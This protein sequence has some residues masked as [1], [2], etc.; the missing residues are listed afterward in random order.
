M[1]MLLHRRAKTP[2]RKKFTAPSKDQEKD[3]QGVKRKAFE[4]DEQT[5]TKAVKG[6]TILPYIVH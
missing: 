2:R 4:G 6:R 5:S 3:P 1:R